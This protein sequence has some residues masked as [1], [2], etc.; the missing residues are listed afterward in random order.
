MTR[1]G[2]IA[3]LLGISVGVLPVRAA[4]DL[5]PLAPADRGVAGSSVEGITDGSSGPTC[6]EPRGGFRLRALQVYGFKPFGLG[7]ADFACASA[8]FGIGGLVDLRL[9]YHRLSV[10]SYKEETY[11]L[12]C[13]WMSG[14]LRLE[15]SVRFGSIRHDGSVLDRAI[16]PDFKVEARPIPELKAVFGVCNPFRLGLLQ[17]GERC[18][19]SIAA[20]FG[21]R[22][23]KGLIFGVDVSKEGGFPTSVATG[24]ELC[25]AEG[26]LLRMG[27]RTEP[28]EFSLG[29][30]LKAGPLAVDVSSSLHLDLGITHEAG[31]TYRRD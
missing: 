26:V 9:G 11:D 4:F 8:G 25:P 14:M 28:R 20:G 31:L 30:G 3:V 1:I 17:S 2:P 5:Q 10:L 23:R 24:A 7:D 18:P 13:A 15:P 6:S 12:A 22:V 21:Y 19:T 16:L 27:L 29:V